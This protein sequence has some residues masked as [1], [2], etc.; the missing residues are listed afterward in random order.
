VN[1]CQLGDNNNPEVVVWK[2]S[3]SGTYTVP[4]NATVQCTAM[5]VCTPVAPGTSVS[6]GSMPLWFGSS[7]R[8]FV[9]Q[10]P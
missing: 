1:V 5:N 3:G 6:V 2:S 8:N 7:N 9:N 10:Q 4:A